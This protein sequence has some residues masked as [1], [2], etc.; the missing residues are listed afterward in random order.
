MRNQNADNFGPPR[1][2]PTTPRFHTIESSPKYI[3]YSI[4]KTLQNPSKP[5]KSKCDQIV[6]DLIPPIILLR[7]VDVLQPAYIGLVE[8]DNELVAT[9]HT[10]HIV[11]GSHN[12]LKQ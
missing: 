2:T 10:N 11:F 5:S 8:F 4:L 1:S 9:K 12:Q 3:H 6:W 7:P